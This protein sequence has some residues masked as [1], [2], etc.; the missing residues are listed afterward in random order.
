MFCRMCGSQMGEDE[1]FCSN[2]GAPASETPAA[3]VAPEVP[4]T[5]V[6][7]PAPVAPV[8]PAPV[9]PV[10][11]NPLLKA[12]SN[13]LY[14]A[15]VICLSVAA[16]FQL[17]NVFTT[18]S[19]LFSYWN[20]SYYYMSEASANGAMVGATV[21]ALGALTIT[22]II[23][24]GLWMVYAS[25]VGQGKATSLTRGLKLVRGGVLAQMIYMIV[26]LALV[27][28]VVLVMIIMGG[29]MSAYDFDDYYY[30]YSYREAGGVI[31]AV[32]VVFLLILAGVGALMIVFYVKART[33]LGHAL[34]EAQTGKATGAPSMFVP[35]MCFIIAGCTVLLLL[36]NNSSAGG[37]I[38]VVSNLA[39]IAANILFGVVALQYRNQVLAS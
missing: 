15:A 24:A 23:L 29:S 32:G 7:A 19:A 28:L 9:A 18:L 3:P 4:V 11:G 17:I 39:T 22:A 13:P 8:A 12:R 30:S 31:A 34:A 27:A 20:D 33:A 1:K 25:G 21:S 36:A 6:A 37:G 14:L 35:V 38:A 2:C 10:A 26:I 16:V 5:P